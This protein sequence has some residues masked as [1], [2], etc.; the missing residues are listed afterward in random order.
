MYKI[1]TATG[2]PFIN[3]ELK[4]IPEYDVV[5]SDIAYQEALIE[6]ITNKEIDKVVLYEMLPGKMDKG[7]FFNKI[8]EIAPKTEFIIIVDKL[9]ENTIQQFSDY[10][11]EKIIQSNHITI[12]ALKEL[13]NKKIE[14]KS[15]KVIQNNNISNKSDNIQI[16]K[17]NNTYKYKIITVNGNNGTGKTTFVVNLAATLSQN[18]KK[19]VLIIDL[20]TVSASVDKFFD[21]PKTYKKL[22]L[23]LDDDKECS[24][25]Y[26]V[27]Y[28][29]KNIFDFDMLSE[30]TVQHNKIKNLH[31]I[32][33]NTSMFV[34][35][36][37]LCEDYYNK[38]IEKA[39]EIY[40]Y[41][42]IDT[43]S[44]L[45]LD[46]TKWALEK[47]NIIYYLIE[48]T[49]KD[50]NNFKNNITIFSKAWG[51]FTD[52]IQVILNKNNIYSLNKNYIESILN[53][54]INTSFDYNNIFLK[55]A[56]NGI[57]AIYLDKII[58]RKFNK[59]IGVQE[60]ENILEKIKFK[61]GGYN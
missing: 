56:N 46:A 54:S 8:R 25:N 39:N 31:I 61:I 38:I 24:L 36:N 49:Y 34:C 35:Q 23:K 57:P 20:D 16:E 2:N 3:E 15:Q 6:I 13:I 59:I 47:A 4:K 44:S 5:F 55:A 7:Y 32:T 26:C 12:D 51:I 58:K 18:S 29:Q 48:G 19:K 1:I 40:D 27:E 50:I 10:N 37:I 22:K 11:I 30:I 45:F 14:S 60:K 17:S 21:V 28:I 41:I 42:I 9:R 33:G 53:I 52:K 43:N